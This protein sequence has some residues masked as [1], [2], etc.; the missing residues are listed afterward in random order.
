MSTIVKIENTDIL[1]N[2]GGEGGIKVGDVI[3]VTNMFI[4]KEVVEGE[5]HDVIAK[6]LGTGVNGFHLNDVL[7]AEFGIKNLFE[8]AK[9]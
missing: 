7:E 1:F 5:E 4:V 9:S 6:A 3:S 2:I 8:D